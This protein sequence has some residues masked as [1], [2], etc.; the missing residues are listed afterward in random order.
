M[1]IKK[2]VAVSFI[3]LLCLFSA[4]FVFGQKQSDSKDRQNKASEIKSRSRIFVDVADAAVKAK[5]EEFFRNE[6]RFK[7]VQDVKE[8]ELV[9]T[10][11]LQA[12]IRPA[13]GTV[14]RRSTLPT[15][16]SGERTNS[17]NTR[18]STQFYQ[19]EYEYRRKATAFVYYNDLNGE[20][21]TLWENQMLLINKSKEPTASIEFSQKKNEEL[22]L[23]KR[24]VKDT[25]AGK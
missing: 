3:L 22:S 10:A 7:V 13:L 16:P 20:R 6:S 5:L 18:N 8:A 14:A 21:V 1:N 17:I 24:F 11:F 19:N 2:T 9:Y 25:K 15:L 23:A 4:P 12:E